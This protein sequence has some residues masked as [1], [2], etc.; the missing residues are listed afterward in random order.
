M[1]LRIALSAR[2]GPVAHTAPVS[3]MLRRHEV[4]SACRIPP[5]DAH[6][7]EKL[8]FAQIRHALAAQAQCGL[9]RELALRIAPSRRIA[10]VVSWLSQAEEFARLTDARGLPPFGGVRDVR[11]MVKRAV[12]PAK[13]EPTEFAELSATLAG[14]DSVRTWFGQ[15]GEG[16]PL[17]ARLIGRLGDFRAIEERISRII[18][19]AGRVRDDA[20]DRLYRIRRDIDEA[21]AG[22]REVFDRLLRQPAVTKYLQYGGATFHDDRMVLPLRA[23][24]RGRIPGIIHRSSDSGQTLFVE[25]AEAVELNNRRVSLLASEA[26]EISRLLWEL[27][28]LV[29]LNQ[30]PI[31]QTLEA[32]AVVDLLSAKVKLSHR[33]Q[34]TW[35]TVQVERRLALRQARNPIL[36]LA[37]DASLDGDSDA[38]RRDEARPLAQSTDSPTVVTSPRTPRRVVP[39]DVRLGED[40][41]IMLLTGPNTGGKTATL[42]T[43]GLIALMAQS[44][45]PI[46]A[47]SGAVLPVFDDIFIDVGDEQSLQQSLSTF[48]G[49]LARILDIVQRAQKTSLVLIDEMGAGTDPDEGA[50]IGRAVLDRLLATGCLAMVTTHLGALKAVGFEQDRVD[51]ACVQFDLETL[52]PTYELRIGEPGNSNALAIASRLGMPK[53]M[54]EAA[55]RHLG[56]RERALSKAIAGT[57]DARRDAERARLDAENARIE[58]A[59]AT[60]AA[61]DRAKVLE[62]QHRAYSNWVQRVMAL[63]AGDRVRVRRFHDPGRVVRVSFEQQKAVVSIGAVEVEVPLADL[64][65][66][67]SPEAVR[68]R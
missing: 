68:T 14:V 42:K 16:C 54:V 41:D 50:A 1:R 35:P 53:K 56:R 59:R 8:E 15:V 5:V 51:N 30:A 29:H 52:R 61:L 17:T 31:L 62:E 43:V 40:F 45:L 47:A 6:T 32:M 26:E 27:T 13:L 60:L 11:A 2:G 12:P 34:L 65:F 9:G 37:F 46:P 38:T 19:H 10:Q 4:L 67:P 3:S 20:S 36:M 23:D 21:R 48:S 66:D 25:P 22:I 49:H 57:L 44:G 24:Q 55:R 39:I 58:A 33:H 18:D 7:L 28:H 63:T 64:T